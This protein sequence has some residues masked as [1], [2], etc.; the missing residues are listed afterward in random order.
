MNVGG[1]PRKCREFA[2]LK[3]LANEAIVA[4]AKKKLEEEEGA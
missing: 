3:R 2:K 1:E 4:C